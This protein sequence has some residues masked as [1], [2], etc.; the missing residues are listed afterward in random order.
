MRAR[1]AQLRIIAGVRE[2]QSAAAEAKA[3]QAAAALKEK[4]TVFAASE[5][6]RADALSFWTACQAREPLPL[7][8]MIASAQ[9]VLLRDAKLRHAA[10]EADAAD[11][12][13]KARRETWMR[14]LVRHR[15]VKDMLRQT[16]T[17]WLEQLDER[18]L[19]VAAERHAWRTQ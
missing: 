8:L 6:A 17:R 1:L 2:A 18:M 7:D 3:L 13:L 15:H 16:R 9:E 10:R 12:E 19:D 11:H 5:K 4:E 14:T